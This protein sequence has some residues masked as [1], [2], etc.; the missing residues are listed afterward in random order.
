MIPF[1]RICGINY[2][3]ATWTPPTLAFFILFGFLLIIY[4][5]ILRFLQITI[6][7]T[8]N[9]FFKYFLVESWMAGKKWCLLQ[10][11]IW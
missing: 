10:A 6:N 8:Y 11:A 9:S 3:M 2:D 1:P 5:I 7:L 4:C